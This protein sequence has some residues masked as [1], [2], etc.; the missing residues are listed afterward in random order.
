[1][2][3]H[4]EFLSPNRDEIAQLDFLLNTIYRGPAITQLCV[5]AHYFSERG[6]CIFCLTNTQ[7]LFGLVASRN[8]VIHLDDRDRS[9]RVVAL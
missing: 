5:G 9:V 8:I 4:L 7:I 3:E 2:E 1:M 6:D